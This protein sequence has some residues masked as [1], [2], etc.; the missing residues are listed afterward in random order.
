MTWGTIT[1]ERIAEAEAPI[2]VPLRRDR[3]QWIEIATRDAIRHFA[4]GIGCNNPLWLDRLCSE[5]ALWDAGCT[6]LHFVCGWHRR[7]AEAV[8][9]S[10]ALCRHGFYLA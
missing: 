10:M 6:T 1:D 5:F 9:R 3:M 2:D 8:R 4:W 7:S